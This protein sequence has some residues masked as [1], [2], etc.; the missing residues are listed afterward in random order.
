M[1][2]IQIP[3]AL[4]HSIALYMKINLC[5]DSIICSSFSASSC[6]Q[7]LK[8]PK[9]YLKEPLS[10][11]VNTML[12]KH[13]CVWMSSIT[14]K[15]KLSISF[16]HLSS[17][18][19][20]QTQTD[21][22]ERRMCPPAISWHRTQICM[23]EFTA[24]TYNISIKRGAEKKQVGANLAVFFTRIWQFM[25]YLFIYFGVGLSGGCLCQLGV[26]F[27]RNCVRQYKCTQLTIICHVKWWYVNV[28]WSAYC[29]ANRLLA[30]FVYSTFPHNGIAFQIRQDIY[31][32][33]T[34]KGQISL[35]CIYVVCKIKSF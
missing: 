9:S 29:W 18:P 1:L 15:K 6:K 12:L 2:F 16:V 19:C 11:A 32:F 24:Q 23:S 33:P 5:C 31:I 22:N 26:L 20:V 14:K 13:S 3:A 8:R 30:F 27:N 28:K 21:T 34:N 10:S 35:T 4:S 7:R 17:T 25:N